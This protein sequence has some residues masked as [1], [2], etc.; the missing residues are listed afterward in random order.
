MANSRATYTGSSADVAHVLRPFVVDSSWY[1]PAPGME[2]R[3]SRHRRLV[4]LRPLLLK[5]KTL[6]PNLSFPRKSFECAVRSAAEGK[7]PDFE[8][9]AMEAASGLRN[10]LRYISSAMAKQNQWVDVI[11]GKGPL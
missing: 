1:R 10:D 4:K 3:A 5:L 8:K 7:I 11:L 6:S 9:H 2:S